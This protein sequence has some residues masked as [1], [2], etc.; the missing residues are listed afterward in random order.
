MSAA[1]INSVTAKDL[2]IA[3][4]EETPATRGYVLAGVRS[5]CAVGTSHIVGRSDQGSLR[6]RPKILSVHAKDLFVAAMD[7]RRPRPLR[8]DARGQPLT[9]G[10]QC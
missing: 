3:A 8:S 2:F 5:L 4:K 7:A 9:G 10:L 6:S 1:T